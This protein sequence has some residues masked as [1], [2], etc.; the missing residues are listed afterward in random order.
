MTSSRLP[1]LNGGLRVAL[2]IAGEASSAVQ[3][4]AGFAGRQNPLI[5]G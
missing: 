1:P 3:L 5:D 2:E 4:N